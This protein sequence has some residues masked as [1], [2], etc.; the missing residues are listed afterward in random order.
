M[1]LLT[2]ALDGALKA[3]MPL[4]FGAVAIDLPDQAV[5]LL[6]GAGVLSFGNRTF[7]GH[8]ETFG[9]IASVE[10]LTDGVGDSAPAFQLTLLPS[11]DA[12]AAHLAAPTMQGS[13]VMVWLGAVDRVTGQPIPDPHLV[14]LGELDVPT[15]HSEE[16]ARRLDY[17]IVSVFERLFEDD[18]SVRLSAGHHRSIFPNEAG[19]DFVTGVAETVYWG[20]PGVQG[21]VSTYSGGAGSYGGQVQP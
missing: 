19:M 7:V 20:V 5:N 21:A 8:D 11:G 12:A 3:D 4:V 17:E 14:F 2:P 13:P 9:T 10:D 1:S 18:E 15:L 6:D 16:H